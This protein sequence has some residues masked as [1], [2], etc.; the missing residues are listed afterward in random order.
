MFDLI[1]FY[2]YKIFKFFVLIIPKPIIKIFLDGL[3]SFIYLINKE[4]KAYAFSNLD[5][6]YKDSISKEQKIDIVKNTYK[7][8]VYNLYEFI[9]NQNNTFE[10]YKKK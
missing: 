5:F 2:I 10:D 3:A 7:T 1:I 9:Q 4:H 8:L 6:V